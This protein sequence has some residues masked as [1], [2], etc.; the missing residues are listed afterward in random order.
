MLLILLPF[1]NTKHSVEMQKMI[2]PVPCLGCVL[3]SPLSRLLLLQLR[4]LIAHPLPLLFSTSYFPP[5]LRHRLISLWQE[6]SDE[7]NIADS[8]HSFAL[9]RDSISEAAYPR[10]PS[11]GPVT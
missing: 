1:G 6:R 8:R 9:A 7:G 5:P 2:V 10:P 3:T 4:L 11:P